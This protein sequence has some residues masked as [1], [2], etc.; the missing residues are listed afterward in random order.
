MMKRQASSL[1]ALAAKKCCDANTGLCI[2]LFS[3]SCL[4]FVFAE[5]G[6]LEWK[7]RNANV[8]STSS[9]LHLHAV[10]AFHFCSQGGLAVGR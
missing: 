5:H 4:G 3:T 2:A 8:V 7:K 6:T 9:D 10:H 1:V